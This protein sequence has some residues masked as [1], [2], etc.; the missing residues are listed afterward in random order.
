M[1]NNNYSRSHQFFCSNK[2]KEECLTYKANQGNSTWSIDDPA[3]S[4]NVL[5]RGTSTSQGDKSSREHT[6]EPTQSQSRFYCQQPPHASQRS[7][8]Q[9]QPL[10]DVK[11]GP[12]KISGKYIATLYYTMSC[13]SVKYHCPTQSY[14]SITPRRYFYCQ[15]TLYILCMYAHTTV[16]LHPLFVCERCVHSD[17][18]I[19]PK[20]GWSLCYR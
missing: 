6:A 2:P 7:Q 11:Q 13:V 9:D 18:H 5:N 12:S 1:D 14:S 4:V 17:S 15:C 3:A 19:E 20:Q 8:A 10:S 16:Q